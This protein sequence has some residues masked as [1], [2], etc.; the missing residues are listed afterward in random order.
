MSAIYAIYTDSYG[1]LDGEEAFVVVTD[2]T[3]T[4][5]LFPLGTSPEAIDDMRQAIGARIAAFGGGDSEELLDSLTYN[6]SV[7]VSIT[8]PFETYEEAMD[9]AQGFMQVLNDFD[10]E[11]YEAYEPIITDGMRRD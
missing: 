8:E 10:P 4:E 7:D 6:M 3:K 2:G 11:L 5:I 9:K 1:Q